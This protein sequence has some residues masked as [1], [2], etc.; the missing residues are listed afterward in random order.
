MIGPRGSLTTRRITA[1]WGVLAAAAL[2]TLVAATVA[3]AL[4]VFAA[5]ALPLA[6]RHDLAVA[7]GTSLAISGPASRDQITADGAQLRRLIGTALPRVPLRFYQAT[8]SD[9]LGLVPGE[10]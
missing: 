4:A 9:P 3:A 7:P 6:A 1:Y 8:W 10:S 5:Q 2:T